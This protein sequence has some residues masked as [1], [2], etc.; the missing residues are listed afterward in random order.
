MTDVVV[1]TPSPQPPT[2]PAGRLQSRIA[3]VTG[4]STGI[5][6]AIALAYAA[7]GARVLCADLRANVDPARSSEVPALGTA[8]EIVARGG[9]AVF[10]ECDVTV[11]EQVRGAVGRAVEFWGRLDIMVNNAGVSLESLAPGPIYEASEDVWDKTMAINLRGVFLG[12]KHA[13][14]QM[15][16][17]EPL[18]S[19]DRG[20]IINVASV[21]GLVAMKSSPA[22]VASKSAVVGLTRSVGIDLAPYRIHANCIAPSYTQTPLLSMATA[23]ISPAEMEGLHALH[24]FKGLGQPEDIAKVAVFFGS[25][26]CSWV[27]S[28]TLAVDGG[29]TAM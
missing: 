25:D 21:M 20:W 2:T 4:S 18:A 24:P 29:F 15:M 27:T 3:L 10:V 28:A 8:E 12:C 7:A 17:Q 1:P 22:Y 16:K 26:D 9:E 13:S 23:L 5:G 11:G 14:A 6:R 19:G